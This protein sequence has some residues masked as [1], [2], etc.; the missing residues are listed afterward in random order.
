M[1]GTLGQF[2]EAAV[3]TATP[4]AVAALGETVV[5]RAGIINIGLEGMILGGAFA[6]LVGAGVGG[7]ALGLVASIGAGMLLALILA[8][9]VLGFRADQIITGTAVNLLAFGLTG[10]LYRSVYGESGAALS[11]PTLRPIE[12]PG[13][14]N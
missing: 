9:F 4:L 10:T 1:S 7:S 2:L 6:A 14:V 3:R 8:A 13:L 11:I 12:V 5:E